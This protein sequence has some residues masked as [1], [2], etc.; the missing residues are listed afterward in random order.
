MGYILRGFVL[1]GLSV[2]VFMTLNTVTS[3]F[4]SNDNKTPTSS[5]FEQRLAYAKLVTSAA[6]EVKCGIPPSERLM[7][8]REVMSIIQSIYSVQIAKSEIVNYLKNVVK[9]IPCKG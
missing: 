1:V 9:D 6:I 3:I 8:S 7:S 5:N 2:F 4:S